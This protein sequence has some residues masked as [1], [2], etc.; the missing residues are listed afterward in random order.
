MMSSS[1]EQFHERATSDIDQL[2]SIKAY[3][4]VQ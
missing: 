1:F 4:I 3:I 2:I